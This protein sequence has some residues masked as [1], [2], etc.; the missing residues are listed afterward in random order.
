MTRGPT[1]FWRK[2]VLG[3]VK[4]GRGLTSANLFKDY[5]NNCELKNGGL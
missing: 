2:G 4:K 1:H 3:Q 5:D